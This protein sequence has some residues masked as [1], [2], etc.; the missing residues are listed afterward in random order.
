MTSVRRGPSRF[1]PMPEQRQ[2]ETERERETNTQSDQGCLAKAGAPLLA[3]VVR[4]YDNLEFLRDIVPER[5]T[6]RK[7]KERKV[8]LTAAVGSGDG[9]G[10]DGA[11]AAGSE[12]AGPAAASAPV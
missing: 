6:V 11:G 12:G 10:G 7:A 4:R 5:V 8:A 2:R 3:K 9:A 1:R